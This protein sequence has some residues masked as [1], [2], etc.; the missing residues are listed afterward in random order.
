MITH[1]FSAFPNGRGEY[2]HTICFVKVS[3]YEGR[4]KIK[5]VEFVEGERQECGIWNME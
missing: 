5:L 2:S 4:L 3:I 1:D